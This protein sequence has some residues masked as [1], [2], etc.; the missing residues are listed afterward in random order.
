MA[1]LRR[2]A[3]FLSERHWESTG[4]LCCSRCARLP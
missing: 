1:I 4:M 2:M 3:F